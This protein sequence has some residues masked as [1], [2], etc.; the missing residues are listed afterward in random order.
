MKWKTVKSLKEGQFKR[1]VGVRRDTFDKMVSEIKQ[2]SK[3]SSHKVPGK[4]RGPK[5][6]LK[7]EDE[8]LIM[9]MYYREYRTFY[10]TGL[11]FGI[12]ESQCWKTVTKIE[13]ILVNC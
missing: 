10:H 6:K 12:S 9:L 2:V 1:L 4:K 13:K 11:E 5:P 8:L 7:A 3:Q